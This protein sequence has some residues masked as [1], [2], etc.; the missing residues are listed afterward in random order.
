MVCVLSSWSL[1]L[2]VLTVC[3]ALTLQDRGPRVPGRV[4]APGAA[5]VPLL[6]VL[7]HP[8]GQRARYR[9]SVLAPKWGPF[10]LQGKYDI[11]ALSA[12]GTSARACA[13]DRL[14]IGHDVPCPTHRSG[15]GVRESPHQ[16]SQPPRAGVRRIA[17]G[18]RKTLCLK[19]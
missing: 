16:T 10:N 19:Q 15:R 7:G 2:T 14:G 6:P 13:R 18:R 9:H 8:R 17:A 3:S 1:L 4:G 12:E 11:R 5:H